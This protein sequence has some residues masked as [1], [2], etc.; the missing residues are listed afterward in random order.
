[1]SATKTNIKEGDTLFKQSSQCE[2]SSFGDFT[3]FEYLCALMKCSPHILLESIYRSP[4]HSDKVFLD[5]LRFC[6]EFVWILTVLFYQDN[7]V[8]M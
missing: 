4:K 1:M 8:C 2:E 7:S 3:S 6:Q 5:E